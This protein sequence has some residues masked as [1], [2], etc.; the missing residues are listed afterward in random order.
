VGPKTIL[1]VDDEAEMPRLG[2]GASSGRLHT[3][4][5]ENGVDALRRLEERG[6][7]SPVGHEDA[8][9]GRIE[10]YRE[11]ER[12]FPKLQRRIIF[13]TGDVLDTGRSSTSSS[14]GVPILRPFDLSESARGARRLVD[15]AQV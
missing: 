5:S 9:H 1:I 14:D 15:A 4:T 6:T 11:M 8:R 12:R 3:E 2:R 7:T 10:L 13:V